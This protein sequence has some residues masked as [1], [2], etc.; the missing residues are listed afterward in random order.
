MLAR[1]EFQPPEPGPLTR[2]LQPL[3]DGLQPVLRPL[4][5]LWE[6]LQ[7]T[8]ER[9]I[10]W[11]AARFEGS[12]GNGS[13]PGWLF[14]L[15]GGLVVAGLGALLLGAFA[16]NVVGGA[17]VAAALIR[18]RAS[19]MATWARA[20]ALAESGAYRAA[21]HELCLATLLTLDE[22]HLLRYR[23]D[24]TN[25]EHLMMAHRNSALTAALAPLVEA[26]DRL[27]YSGAD[28]G[29]AEW[30][31]FLPLADAA[32]AVPAEAE[33]GCTLNGTRAHCAGGLVTRWP[34]GS[35]L[36]VLTVALVVVTAVFAG[37][38]RRPNPR[39]RYGRPTRTVGEPS[40]SGWKP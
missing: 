33:P 21:V 39:S 12:A 13:V 18:P 35:P 11:L 34:A 7:R 29:A 6:T 32:R 31:A 27:W 14:L 26:Y 37:R 10:R 2:L 3:I 1:A 30:A 16:G 5:N 40:R 38:P 20:Q 24:L 36:I 19:A 17:R 4:M 23:A 25:R 8:W 9:F 15:L 28:V 22:R